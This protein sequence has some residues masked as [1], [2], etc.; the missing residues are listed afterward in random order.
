MKTL[1]SLSVVRPVLFFLLIALVGQQSR[2][3]S[4]CSQ[5]FTEPYFSYDQLMGLKQRALKAPNQSIQM[6]ASKN[7]W[8]E[9]LAHAQ[10]T[11]NSNITYQAQKTLTTILKSAPLK[12]NSPQYLT[13]GSTEVYLVEFTS[14]VKALFKPNPQHWVVDS[15]KPFQLLSNSYAEV[16]AYQLARIYGLPEIPLTVLR[17]IDGKLGSLQLY[18]EG[19]MTSPETTQIS[20]EIRRSLADLRSFDYIIRNSDRVVDSDNPNLIFSGKL[21]WGID[22]GSS[23]LPNTIP[24]RK[25]PQLKDLWL[26]QMSLSFIA[27][28]RATTPAMI[29]Q[30]LKPYI[31][32]TTIAQVI[33]RHQQ[34]V[35]ALQ[36]TPPSNH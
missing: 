26:N 2:S 4:L 24:L 25:I 32:Q 1:I 6:A 21:L 34:L 9:V 27:N 11:G 30:S 28:L 33:S 12:K 20:P 3:A 14:G 17:N 8:A 7:Q 35:Q 19:Q 16:A 23:F 31:E 22:H 18:V 13:Q 29:E 36:N 15:K 5:V 10:K